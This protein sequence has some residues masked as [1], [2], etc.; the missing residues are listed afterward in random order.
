M[1]IERGVEDRCERRVHLRRRDDAGREL[2]LARPVGEL[3]EPHRLAEI[4]VAGDLDNLRARASGASS[5][6]S[7][8]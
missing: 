1:R 3:V 6:S 4:L 8:R 5:R 2:D 7:N